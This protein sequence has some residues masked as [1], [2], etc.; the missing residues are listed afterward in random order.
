MREGKIVA[1]SGATGGLGPTVARAFLD[2]GSRLAVSGRSEEHLA[3]L[4][5]SLPGAAERCMSTVVDL[6]DGAG[7]RGWAD[8]VVRKLGRVDIVV[9]LVGGYRG[10]SSIGEIQESDWDF[11]HATLVRTTLNVVRAFVGPLSSNGWG[12]FLAVTSP[13]A[14]A[15]TAKNALYAMAKS[16]SD[17]LVLAMASELAGSG[18]TANLIMVDSIEIPGAGAAPQKKAYGKSTPAAEIAAAM[19]FLCSDEAAT[20]NGVRLPLIGRG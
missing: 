9:H 12:R 11:L 8:L 3:R 2:A 14:Q 15:P 1:I 19:L 6:M 17:A 13:R 18:A 16:A 10:G 4:L 7:T 20:I 5:D